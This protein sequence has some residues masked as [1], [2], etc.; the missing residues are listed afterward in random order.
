MPLPEKMS[1]FELEE[2]IANHDC[3]LS[4]DSGCSCDTLRDILQRKQRML[5]KVDYQIINKEGKI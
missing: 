3:K 2:A 1:T 4:P 5:N